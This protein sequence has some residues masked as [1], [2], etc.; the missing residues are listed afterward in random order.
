MGA[1]FP[2]QMRCLTPVALRLPGLESPVARL[3]E[4]PPGSS[5]SC[6][7]YWGYGLMLFPTIL[8][9]AKAE[10]LHKGRH[11]AAVLHPVVGDAPAIDRRVITQ[12]LFH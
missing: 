1:P 4:A 9:G 7:A 6:S 3:S 8:L 5:W 2:L 10:R 12:R 11:H